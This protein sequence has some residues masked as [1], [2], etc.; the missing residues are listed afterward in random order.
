MKVTNGIIYIEILFFSHKA[1]EAQKKFKSLR[2]VY[3]RKRKEQKNKGKSG[4]KGGVK[5][6]CTWI[7]Y[8]LMSFLQPFI[9]TSPLV[10]LRTIY[11]KIS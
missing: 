1:T 11:L 5:N 4:S 9:K 7:H 6:T 2:D 3:A 10:H 8:D